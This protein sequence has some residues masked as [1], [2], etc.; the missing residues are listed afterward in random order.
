[1]ILFSEQHVVAGLREVVSDEGLQ[2]L[3]AG[4]GGVAGEGKGAR[5]SIRQSFGNGGEIGFLKI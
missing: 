1:M 2:L 5:Y 3:L 4:D